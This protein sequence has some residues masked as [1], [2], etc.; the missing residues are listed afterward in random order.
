MGLLDNLR[1]WFVPEDGIDKWIILGEM[2]LAK[3]KG[4]EAEHYFVRVL[5]EK[6]NHRR[7]RRGIMKAWL[8]QGKSDIVIEFF[9]ELPQNEQES[10]QDFLYLALAME[11]G[12]LKK[13]G[14]AQ[15]CA[16]PKNTSDAFEEI[17]RL[18]KEYNKCGVFSSYWAE[19][20]LEHYN[21]P[22]AQ[23]AL[24]QL[25]DAQ[26][27]LPNE[28]IARLYTKRDA[29]VLKHHSELFDLFQTL[30]HI[31]DPD[32][33]IDL[34]EPFASKF[35][36]LAPVQHEMGMA[37]Y[38]A[39]APEKAI[40]FLSRAVTLNPYWENAWINLAIVSLAA[41]RIVRAHG[42]FIHAYK[43]NKL[44]WIGQFC[45]LLDEEMIEHPQLTK[46]EVGLDRS[47][48]GD[49]LGAARAFQDALNHDPNDPDINFWL[50]E[51]WFHFGDYEQAIPFLRVAWEEARRRTLAFTQQRKEI[52]EQCVHAQVFEFIR[53]EQWQS[54]E[55]L[56]EQFLAFD[57]F[58]PVLKEDFALLLAVR[59][60]RYSLD[61]ILQYEALHPYHEL[62]T[63]PRLQ[64]LD[65]LLQRQPTFSEALFLKALLLIEIGK[66]PEAG[67]LLVQLLNS[68]WR[69][70]KVL[71]HLAAVAFFRD[72]PEKA[73]QLWNQCIQTNDPLYAPFARKNIDNLKK[74][75]PLKIAWA[76]WG[77]SPRFT[78]IK[79]FD[80]LSSFPHERRSSEI[81][82]L[83]GQDLQ[84]HLEQF[85]MDQPS[86]QP[87]S[88]QT[89]LSSELLTNISSEFETIG[90]QT[91]SG[92]DKDVFS[93]AFEEP[94]QSSIPPL[95]IP[96]KLLQS[97]Q[98]NIT[99]PHLLDANADTVEMPKISMPSPPPSPENNMAG[100]TL[101]MPMVIDPAMKK[102]LDSTPPPISDSSL[103]FFESFEDV[104]SDSSP[105]ASQ[106]PSTIEESENVANELFATSVENQLDAS[107]FSLQE[108][109]EAIENIASQDSSSPV[110]ATSSVPDASKA[111]HLFG[112]PEAVEKFDVPSPEELQLYSDKIPTLSKLLPEEFA[113]NSTQDETLENISLQTTTFEVT[114]R[115]SS[116][117]AFSADF[118]SEEREREREEEARRLKEEEEALL[119]S[120]ESSSPVFGESSFSSESTA[121]NPV[122]SAF[123]ENMPS[124]DL[125]ADDSSEEKAPSSKEEEQEDFEPLGLLPHERV[126][127][128]RQKKEENPRVV[129]VSLVE[130]EG[131]EKGP[132]INEP[133]P[134]SNALQEIDP[135]ASLESFSEQSSEALPFTD[136]D[137]LL[138][139]L[140]EAIGTLDKIE[141]K[142]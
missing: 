7:A 8:L 55:T 136:E 32:E 51:A 15:W 20:A 129:E 73:I 68:G 116:E 101:E 28:E 5:R 62:D 25:R 31:T 72:D 67:A 83:S 81:P 141:K 132:K 121:E 88:Q 109:S 1:R 128:Q 16:T 49:Y 86:S 118:F 108:H 46:I 127:Q 64:Q 59:E 2:S 44:E 40:R 111:A 113:E 41:N 42:A 37:F 71:F 107:F 6:E 53:L 76:F 14:Y 60:K 103:E 135:L 24:R 92:K 95:A 117:L 110:A 27:P 12:S 57:P 3:A 124:T 120:L 96:E 77:S 102:P 13:E 19:A 54:A 114:S 137:D 75:P 48:M 21:L 39:G 79:S 66:L 36:D 34:L 29:T 100:S 105:F 22:D 139:F 87:Q 11:V 91:N 140:D 85:Q 58:L 70:S 78:T 52:V 123:S 61:D 47:L 23:R 94:Q 138:S 122:I 106:Q 45:D 97:T 80:A 142:K 38:E 90:V 9:D 134:L 98:E 131:T 82:P 112:D 50:G 119:K 18:A 4:S 74:Q 30:S 125:L 56:L 69:P 43:M 115:T 10:M 84:Q 93:T 63:L 35:M 89:D 99:S 130:E 133:E 33:K 17:A 104:E 126:R 65:A 26:P